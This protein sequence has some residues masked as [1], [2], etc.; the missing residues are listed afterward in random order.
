MPMCEAKREIENL[1]EDIIARPIPPGGASRGCWCASHLSPRKGK[2][3]NDATRAFFGFDG[4]MIRSG[5][6]NRTSDRTI[7]MSEISEPNSSTLLGPSNQK[8]KLTSGGRC[9]AHPP[10]FPPAHID[11]YRLFSYFP[12]RLAGNGSEDVG[13]FF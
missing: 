10:T 1:N 2:I 9:A 7:K 6:E 5:P 13:F 8:S 3:G 12:S 11:S 4:E